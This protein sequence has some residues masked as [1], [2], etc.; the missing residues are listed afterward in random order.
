MGKKNKGTNTKL[1]V[2]NKFG[3]IV[4][5]VLNEQSTYEEQLEEVLSLHPGHG[6][7]VSIGAKTIQVRD[8]FAGETV[9][10]FEII[11]YERTDLPQTLYWEEEGQ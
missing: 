8:Y 6:F 2:K 7:S 9:G 11:S 1:T 3:K 10:E 4:Y 5:C